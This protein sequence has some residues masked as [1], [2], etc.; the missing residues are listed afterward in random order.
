MAALI[1]ED[2]GTKRA[3]QGG[4]FDFDPENG[5]ELA[6]VKNIL[7]SRRESCGQNQTVTLLSASGEEAE[8]GLGRL[9]SAVLAL[10]HRE[11]AC[12][13]PNVRTHT[14]ISCRNP[15]SCRCINHRTNDLS[16]A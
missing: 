1:L 10:F 7:A 6:S 12:M 5:N 4:Y 9:L 11:P 16:V 13:Q 3:D 15:K 2:G 8:N 14:S